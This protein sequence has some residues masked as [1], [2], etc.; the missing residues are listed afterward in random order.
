MTLANKF[1][2]AEVFILFCFWHWLYIGMGLD[3]IA[4]A[5]GFWLSYAFMWWVNHTIVNGFKP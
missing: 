3:G 5:T 2:V 1:L 4:T